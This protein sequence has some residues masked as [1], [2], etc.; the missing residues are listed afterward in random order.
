MVVHDNE[1][2]LQLAASTEQVASFQYPKSGHAGMLMRRTVSPYE[3]SNGMLLG[4]DHD[5]EG[6]RQFNIA[7]IVGEIETNPDDEFV[8]PTN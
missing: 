7:R 8:H 2:E 6:L 5:R 4:W 1:Y 3:L